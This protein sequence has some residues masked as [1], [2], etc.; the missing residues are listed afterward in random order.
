[1]KK[2]NT[3]KINNDVNNIIVDN[4]KKLI[5]VDN[6]K[7]CTNKYDDAIA[8]IDKDKQLR[9]ADIARLVG[10]NEKK[11]RSFLRRNENL[12]VARKQLFNKTSSLFIIMFNAAI[13]YK[14]TLS[15]NGT[16]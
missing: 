8:K 12:Y 15:S 6:A 11:Y 5:V 1:M 7:L 10:I 16:I 2:Q 9:A 3:Q 13:E 4:A 14:K